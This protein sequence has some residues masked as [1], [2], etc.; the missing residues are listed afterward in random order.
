[1]KIQDEFKASLGSILEK[2]SRCIAA[3]GMFCRSVSMGINREVKYP[4]RQAL[5]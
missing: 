4:E 3:Q 2:I 5:D 1:M